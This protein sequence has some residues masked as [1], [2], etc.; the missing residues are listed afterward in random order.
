MEHIFD[1]IYCGKVKVV[2]DYHFW[3]LAIVH[4]FSLG[5]AGTFR[6]ESLRLPRT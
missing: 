1:D 5:E 2:P 3:A 6:F 4:D